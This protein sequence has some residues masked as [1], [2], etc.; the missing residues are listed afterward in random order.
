MQIARLW[1]KVQMEF[2]FTSA[3][4]ANCQYRILKCLHVCTHTY[5]YAHV[6]ICLYL[7]IYANIYIEVVI[8]S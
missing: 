4:S 2:I 6:Y 8:N 5:M 7:N 3:P 1:A